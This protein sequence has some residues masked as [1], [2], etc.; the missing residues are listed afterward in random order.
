MLE[1]MLQFLTM[2][3]TPNTINAC[4]PKYILITFMVVKG[5]KYM[6]VRYIRDVNLSQL[7]D[8]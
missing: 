8:F 4:S 7:A 3:E 5:L 6:K 1:R 2:L